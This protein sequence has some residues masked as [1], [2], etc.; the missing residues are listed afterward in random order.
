MKNIHSTSLESISINGTSHEVEITV[1]YEVDDWDTDDWRDEIRGKLERGEAISSV[2]NVT[3]TLVHGGAIFEGHD[4]LGGCIIERHSDV[5]SKVADYDM[6]RT[7]IDDLM[8]E[9]TQK[10]A[11]LNSIFGN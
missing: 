11:A 4:D 2:V 9:M 7:A 3:A 1:S 8:S 10:R 6:I 5:T